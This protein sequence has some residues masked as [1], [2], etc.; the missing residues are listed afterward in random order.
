MFDGNKVIAL[1][2]AKGEKSKTFITAIFGASSHATPSYFKGKKSID[3]DTLEKLAK[4][5]N[6][7][8]ESFF[9]NFPAPTG[10]TIVSNNHHNTFSIGQSPE[11]LQQTIKDLQGVVQDKNEMIDYLKKQN[12]QLIETFKISNN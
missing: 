5:F 4:H 8:M 2:K 6:V 12:I 1:F 9:D 11:V 10:Q 3:S 7:P